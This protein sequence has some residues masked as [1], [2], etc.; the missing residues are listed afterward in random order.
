VGP[1]GFINIS[2]NAKK[3]V[4]LG[5][6]TAGGLK[7]AVEDGKLKSRTGG[8]RAEVPH[9]VRADHFQWQI[10]RA[11]KT[12]L[13]STSR[14]AAFFTLTQDGMELTRSPRVLISKEGRLP[15][16]NSNP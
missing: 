14:N 3:I 5:T 7:A 9:Q 11:E 10:R 6:F 15:R 12:A 13:C 8:T 2:Q 16:W 1:G 4:F